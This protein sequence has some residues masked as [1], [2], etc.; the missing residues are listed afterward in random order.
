MIK[1][2][3][4]QLSIFF[5]LLFFS[6]SGFNSVNAEQQIISSCGYLKITKTPIAS[7]KVI[8]TFPHDSESFTEG[9]VYHRGYLYESTGLKGK[10]SLKKIEIKSSKVTKEV[11]LDAEYFGEGI[12]ILGNKIYQL[13]WQNQTGFVYDLSSFKKVG[14]FSYQG[15][16]WGLATDGKVLFMSDGSSEISCIDPTSFATIL[17]IKVLD[18]QLPV[19]NLNELEFVRGELWANIFMEDVIVRIS[20]RTGNV[21]GWIDLS[22]LHLMLKKSGKRDVLNGIAYDPQGDRIFVTG[23]LWPKLF[24]IKVQ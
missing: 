18:G 22:P 16:G 14:K 5:L 2:I 7:I 24:E 23:K 13:T 21:L 8:N 3:L 20:P 11:K 9:L 4:K 17:K 19:T 15:E 10:S 12:A 6:Y 1:F